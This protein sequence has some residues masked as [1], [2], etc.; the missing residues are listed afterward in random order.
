[1]VAKELRDML[2]EMDRE[3]EKRDRWRLEQQTAHKEQLRKEAR[4]AEAE[5][6]DRLAWAKQTNIWA[7]YYVRCSVRCKVRYHSYM[8]SFHTYLLLHHNTPPPHSKKTIIPLHHD[9]HA[10]KAP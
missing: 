8:T 9:N 10:T 4:E 1:M 7:A 5:Q 2:L 6:A 3:D